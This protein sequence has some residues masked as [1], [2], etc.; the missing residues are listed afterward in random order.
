MYAIIS[1]TS[2]PCH[3]VPAPNSDRQPCPKHRPHLS[4]AQVSCYP[5]PPGDYLLVK[6]PLELQRPPALSRCRVHFTLNLS[7][8]LCNQIQVSNPGWD[9]LI[10]KRPCRPPEA[11]NSRGDTLFNHKSHRS[12]DH[13]GNRYQGT[14]TSIQQIYTQKMAPRP[15]IIPNPDA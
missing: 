9:S 6:R 5:N 2:P 12:K 15:M 7:S 4:D 3:C 14:K 8:I 13:R 10:N 11:S 1:C